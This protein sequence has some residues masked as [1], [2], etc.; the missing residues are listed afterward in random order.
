MIDVRLWKDDDLVAGE[1]GDGIEDFVASVDPISVT[2]DAA[3]TRVAIHNKRG[4]IAVPELA[5]GDALVLELGSNRLNC[6]LVS[7]ERIQREGG[8]LPS[9][10]SADLELAFFGG[11]K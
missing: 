8:G 11:P 6:V 5:Y 10:S 1:I 3:I 7:I 4:L 2:S 9:S